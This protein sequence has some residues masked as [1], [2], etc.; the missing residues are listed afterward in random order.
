M[1]KYNNSIEV[2]IFF[3]GYI[4]MKLKK[5]VTCMLA[6]AIAAGGVMSGMGNYSYLRTG[7]V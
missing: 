4:I 7:I 5:I 3:E 2:R 6:A 1:R